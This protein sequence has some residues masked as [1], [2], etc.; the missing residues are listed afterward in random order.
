MRNWL[1]AQPTWERTVG[2]LNALHHGLLL[3]G[4]PGTAKREFAMALSQL[5][6]CG[7]PNAAQ[8]CGGCQN[9]VLFM[10]GTHPDFHALTTELEWRDGR[11]KLVS[12]YCNRYQDIA[13]REKRAAPSRVIAVDYIRLLIERFYTH[14]HISARKV[15]LI[16]PAERMNINAANALLK[17]LEEPPTNSIFILV[18]ALPGNLPAT[19]RSRCVQIGLPLPTDEVA[20]AWLRQ[21]MSAAEATQALALTN[22]GP[23]EAGELFAKGLLPLQTEFLQGLA[24]LIAGKIGA[25]ALAA[26]FKPHDFLQWLDWLHRFSCEL[27][28][29]AC[30]GG[31]PRWHAQVRLDLEHARRSREKMFALYDQI[32]YYRKIAQEPLNEQLAMEELMFALQRA[33][34][35]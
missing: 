16:V 24:E 14:A 15:A 27:S 33:V 18:S 29:W 6:L 2:D 4:A 32:G 28:K 1:W 35:N 13:A 19:I 17:L 31:V 11:M 9:C 26:R 7:E 30:G 10:A 8:P 23:V 5:L 12:A 3:T 25:V 22:G 20:A 34:R 21:H